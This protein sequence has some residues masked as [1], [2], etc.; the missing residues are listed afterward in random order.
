MAPLIRP[1]PAEL[2]ALLL[3]MALPD[4]GPAEL[5]AA[6]RESGG[7]RQAAARLARRRLPPAGSADEQRIR[8]WVRT[9]R[10][11]VEREDM[12][13]ITLDMEAYPD[14]FRPLHIPPYAIFAQGRLSML[15]ERCVAIVGTRTSTPQGRETTHRMATELAAAGIHVASGLA[16]GIDGVAHRAAGP[17]RTIAVVG[18]GLDVAYPREHAALQAD[19]AREGLVLSEFLPGSPPTRFNFPRRNRLIAAAAQAVV[20]VEA[21]ERSGALLTASAGIELGKTIFAVPGSVHDRVHAGSNALY[22]QGADVATG[23]RD[24]LRVMEWP[25]TEDLAVVETAPVDLQGLGLALWHALAPE[26]PKHV[27]LVA[28][29]LGL[30]PRECLASLLALEIQGH[31]R[32]LPGMRFLR[33]RR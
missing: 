30:E 25:E 13:V 26:R 16:R 33:E 22:Q 19:I 11:A 6:V 9:A 15:E 20:V 14:R 23:A 27:D 21:P 3:A 7:I 29:D 1:D 2:D 24:V 8:G 31:A 28:G 17:S 4:V 10:A 12:H 5:T 32:Q 18:C